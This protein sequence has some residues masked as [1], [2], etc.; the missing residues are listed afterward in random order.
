MTTIQPLSEAIALLEDVKNWN[1]DCATVN[2]ME[3]ALTILRSM[4]VTYQVFNP[5]EAVWYL[6]SKEGFDETE[7]EHRRKIIILEENVS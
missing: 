7:R 5:A 2:V 4:P 6:T 3:Q 1:S